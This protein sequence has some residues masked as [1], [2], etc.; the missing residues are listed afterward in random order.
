MLEEGDHHL[1][2]IVQFLRVVALR[3]FEDHLVL[4]FTIDMDRHEEEDVSEKEFQSLAVIVAI[5][6]LHYSR[7]VLENGDQGVENAS[8]VEEI[9]L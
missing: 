7:L 9:L 5:N 2:P 3:V 4:A 1:E 6:C 8:V